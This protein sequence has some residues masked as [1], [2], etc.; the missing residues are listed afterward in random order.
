MSDPMI[1][2]EHL[3]AH[4]LIVPDVP[5]SLDD[6]QEKMEDIGLEAKTRHVRDA[7]FWGLPV[8]TPLG[9][10]QKPV[11]KNG[12]SKR[13]IASPKGGGR[14]KGNKPQP[15][16]GAQKDSVRKAQSKRRA[17]FKKPTVEV[18]PTTPTDVP[19]KKEPSSLD[20]DAHILAGH[21]RENG[22]GTKDDPIDVK[23]DLEKA[24]KLL[25]EGKHIRLNSN[26]EVGT[27]LHR[28]KEIVDEAKA[29]GDTS[30]TYDLCKV[31]V[32]GT[33]LFCVE[34]KGVLREKMPQFKNTKIRPGSDA[35]KKR[36]HDP[37]WRDKKG[38]P[39]EVSVEDEFVQSL[40]DKGIELS[41]PTDVP[42]SKL[43]ASQDEVNGGKVVG[44][45]Q[46]MREGKIPEAPI[47]I[48]RDG[49]IVDGHHRWAAK[50]AVDLD[51]GVRGDVTMPVRVIDMDIMAALEYANDFTEKMGLLPADVKEGI[52]ALLMG[53]EVKDMDTDDDC[54]CN[55]KKRTLWDV[56]L[57]GNTKG[58]ILDL[59]EKVLDTATIVSEVDEFKG[60]EDTFYIE[61]KV[62]HVRDPEYWGLPYGTVLTPGMKPK[63]KSG[64]KKP[65]STAK[66]P[67]K[68]PTRSHAKLRDEVLL[69][70]L[71][72][73]KEA[74]QNRKGSYEDY[75]SLLKEASSRTSL[76]EDLAYDAYDD[77]YKR[78]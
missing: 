71:A 19:K 56:F 21:G 18:T 78:Y 34:S 63:P 22:R 13:N 62:R 69:E 35:D 7:A 30:K 44:M 67:A 14:P 17:P 52:K 15:V 5:E 58:D 50:V 25:E 73:A 76:E 37:S 75:E 59:A 32:P 47:F 48:T 55:K 74:Y 42:A 26:K 43:K 3:L 29:S 24:V 51:D 4:A 57:D 53:I 8:G 72:K 66:P 36:K 38:N 6:I 77:T 39:E 41:D 23:G 65:R 1:R 9:A 61:N 49:Y 11:G 40:I 28:L 33:N 31:A 2:A 16:D 60:L 70:R 27:L 20:L 45:A 64:S 54:G 12:V 68:K 46:A 10:N